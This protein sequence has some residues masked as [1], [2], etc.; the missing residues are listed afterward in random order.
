MKYGPLIFLGVFFTLAA[1]WCGLVLTPQLQYGGLGEIRIEETGRAYPLAPS[2]LAESGRAVYQA[3]GCIYCHSQQVR[4]A[5]FGADLARGWGRRR[6]VSR[7]YVWDQPVMLGTMRTGPDLA[8]IGLRQPSSDWHFSHLYDPQITSKGSVMAPFA[9]LFEK[10]K[11]GLRASPG[12]LKL[13]PVV[14]P[15]PGWEIVPKPEAEALVAYLLSLKVDAALPEAP[16][17]K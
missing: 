1:S 14:A 7:D 8:N 12:A 4:E 17:G 10:R 16:L 2:G 5:G 9:F 11:V 6:S 3:N 15:E 13:P